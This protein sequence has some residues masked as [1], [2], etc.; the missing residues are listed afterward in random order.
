[1][2]YKA[3]WVQRDLKEKK[4]IL[5]HKAQKVIVV[6]KVLLARTLSEKLKKQ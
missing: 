2:D 5:A 6:N 3:Q 4:V 1:M